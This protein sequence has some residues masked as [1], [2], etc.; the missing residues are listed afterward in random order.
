[1]TDETA[2]ALL[3]MAEEHSELED[4]VERLGRLLAIARE[5]LR[6]ALRKGDMLPSGCR[7]VHEA[8]RESDPEVKG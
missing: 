8:L 3:V 5:G 1:M 6:T 4:E 7:A 2:L